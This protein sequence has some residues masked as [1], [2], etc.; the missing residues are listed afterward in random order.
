VRVVRFS[1][2]RFPHKPYIKEGFPKNV[3]ALAGD[4]A[5]LQCPTLSDLEPYI[6]WLKVNFSQINDSFSIPQGVVVQVET[7]HSQKQV[8]HPGGGANFS[9]PFSLLLLLLWLGSFHSTSVIYCASGY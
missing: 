1:T 2:E 6:Q 3:T 9:P 4:L 7:Q 8:S 5:V